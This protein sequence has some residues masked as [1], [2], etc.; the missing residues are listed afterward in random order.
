MDPPPWREP[1]STLLVQSGLALLIGLAGWQAAKVLRFPAATVLGPMILVGVASCAGAVDVVVPVWVRLAL[2]IIIGVFAGYRLDQA[3]ARRVRKMGKPVL[4]V[5]AWT[6]GSAL[7][8]GFLLHAATGLDWPTAFL[9]TAPG[10]LPE[11]SAMA[12]TMQANTAMVATLSSARLITTLL[13]VPFLARRKANGEPASQPPRSAFPSQDGITATGSAASVSPPDAP[14]GLHWSVCLTIGVGGGCLFSWLQVP[15]AGVIGSIMAVGAARVSG[16]PLRRPPDA[17]RTVAQLGIGILIGT[18]FTPQ[19]AVQLA[20]NFV[21]VIAAASALVAGGLVLS[22]TLQRTVGLD[23]PT[24]LLAC[25]PAGLSQMAAL[26]E[27][28]GAQT[29]IV[30]IFQLTRTLTVVLIL[31]VIFRLLIPQ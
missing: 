31:P 4:A 18:T 29:F 28:L 21:A 22:R 30:S 12:L 8:I 1:T 11:M 6:I 15:A 24:A 19:T 16:L 20:H 17:L 26:S 27:E 14:I 10:S 2:Q 23:T 13:T 25:S 5:T 7:L 3:A 9:G